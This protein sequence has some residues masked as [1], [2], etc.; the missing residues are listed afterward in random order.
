M[1]R[2][3][4][5]WAVFLVMA[6][7]ALAGRPQ[8]VAAAPAAAP[9]NLTFDKAIVDPNGIWQGQVSG[10]LEGELTTVLTGLEVS[11]PIWR[12]EF[13]WI[14]DTGDEYSF[15]AT[16]SG[17][18]NTDTGQVVMNGV[19][20]DGY[21]LGAQVHEEGQLMDADTLQFEGLIRIMPASAG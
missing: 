11:G 12:V 9:V 18:L 4:V 19:V 10:D 17:I 8:F 14:L 7:L 20:S 1:S 15:T 5:F 2:F 16:L 6:G 21:L 13:D 3:R